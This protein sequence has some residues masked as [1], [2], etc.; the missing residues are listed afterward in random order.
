VIRGTRKEK[1]VRSAWALSARAASGEGGVRRR[2]VKSS[3][4]HTAA[5]HV[6]RHTSSDWGRHGPREGATGPGLSMFSSSSPR[7]TLPLDHDLHHPL[8]ARPVESKP[9]QLLACRLRITL[10]RSRLP[11]QS[12]A[13]LT[14]PA[15]SRRARPLPGHRSPS[16][17]GL[18][19][20][21]LATSVSARACLLAHGRARWHRHCGCAVRAC[22]AARVRRRA[23]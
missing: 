5:D 15:V 16:L 14:P 4:P 2:A 9:R 23:R 19:S 1:R 8:Q 12:A 13:L 6:P 7:Q 11:L 21:L 17:S 18:L 3:S 20:V 22:D 10:Q